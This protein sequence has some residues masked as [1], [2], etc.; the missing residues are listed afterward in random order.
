MY[1]SLGYGALSAKCT[2]GANAL[3]I[4]G[5]LAVTLDSAE[6]PFVKTP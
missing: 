4:F 3:G 5:S 1:A 2:A 6:I